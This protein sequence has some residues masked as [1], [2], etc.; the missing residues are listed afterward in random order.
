MKYIITLF[1]TITIPLISF[2]KEYFKKYQAIADSF[3]TI[4]NIPSSVMLGVAALE[5]GYGKSN[6]AKNLNNH[7]GI[8]SS[9]KSM[10]TPKNKSKYRQFSSV[11]KSFEEF[12]L[13]IRLKSFYS[14]LR[15]NIDYTKWIY[16]ISKTNYVNPSK[17]KKWA[18]NIISI[19]KKYYS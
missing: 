8:I 7:F 1:I 13:I 10:Q 9:E 15:G 18:L 3:E 19:I 5:S 6:A 16:A 12:C 2:G 17:S 4:Y 11:E 14:K